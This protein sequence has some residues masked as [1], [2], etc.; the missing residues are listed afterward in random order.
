MSN[1]ER[2]ATPIRRQYL[3]LKRKYADC[4]LFFRL[5]DFYETF[6][7]DAE[8]ISRELDIY[9]T[10]R[11]IA[12]DTRVP[13]AGVPHHAAESY[14]ARLIERGYRVAI[15]EQMGS[16]AING[17]VPREVRRV[18][19][20]GTVVEAGML[21]A[22]KPS[23][24]AAIVGDWGLEIEDASNRQSPI[25]HLGLAYCDITTGEFC[26]AQLDSEL[27]LQRELARIQPREMVVP[28]KAFSTA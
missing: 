12:K 19:T 9:L 27:E 4:I 20:P 28:E 8:L 10:S 5:G 15:A 23:Y 16:E 13:M 7:S 2:E 1:A 18:M 25:S 6:D 22:A 11:P 3:E 26:A 17:L 21:D 24:L 14:I